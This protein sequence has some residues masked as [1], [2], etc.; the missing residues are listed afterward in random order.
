MELKEPTG[1]ISPYYEKV[2]DRLGEEN[3]LSSAAP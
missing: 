3:L 2:L 1:D